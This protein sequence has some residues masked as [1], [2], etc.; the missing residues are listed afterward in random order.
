MWPTTVLFLF[1]PCRN[2]CAENFVIFFYEIKLLFTYLL[3]TSSKL[4]L[5]RNLSC[6]YQATQESLETS[7]A[8]VKASATA[9]NGPSGPLS[10]ASA[11]PTQYQLMSGQQSC[12]TLGIECKGALPNGV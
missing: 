4:A 5:V 3:A 11:S 7:L 8:D 12:R 2:F 9:P 1:F 10:Y 6:G